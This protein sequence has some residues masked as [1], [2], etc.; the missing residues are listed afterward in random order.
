M[1]T[2]RYFPRW[3]PPTVEQ[4][5]ALGNIRRRQTVVMLWWIALIPAGW[6]VIILTRSD[7]MLAP[8]T[9]F[10]VAFGVEFA[11][12]LASVRCP[13][14]GGSFCEKPG[15]PYIYGMFNNRCESCGLTL[16]PD[17]DGEG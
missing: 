12:R 8:L 2:R 6:M 5:A 13:R 4:R 17:R 16:I 3:L 14:C 10:W 7:A 11:R 15:M 1:A 9:I